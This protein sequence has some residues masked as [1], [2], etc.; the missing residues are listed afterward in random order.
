MHFILIVYKYEYIIN[1]S[2]Y[3]LDFFYV[4][5]YFLGHAS[6]TNWC[7]TGTEPQPR[8]QTSL[9]LMKPPGHLMD[10]H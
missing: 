4:A 7:F 6:L 5:W 9:N 8:N 1:K 3:F 2:S 10:W